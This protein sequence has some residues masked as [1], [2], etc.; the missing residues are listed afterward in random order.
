VI[1]VGA[2]P[3]GSSCATILAHD[4][5]RVL[6]VEKAK[7]P[8]EKICGDC[9]NP[10]SW[11]FFDLLGVADT[12][13]GRR[14]NVIDSIRVT[15]SSGTA[16]IGRLSFRQERPF[17][18]ISRSELDMLLFQ[19]ACQAGAEG[20]EGV[21][22]TD[23]RW[24]GHWH[25]ETQAVDGRPASNFT[26]RYLVG[27][28]G[29][30]SFVARKLAEMERVPVVSQRRKR[31]GTH[32]VGVQ[33]RTHYQPQI[34]K[35]VEMYLFKTGY[36]G[37]VNVDD[38]RATVAM[39]TT[40]QLARVAPIDL[41]CFVQSTL[42][43]NAAARTRFDILRPVGRV[44]TACPINPT[45]HHH[46]HHA[47]F[48]A[49]DAHQTV[50]PFTGEGVFFALQ[51]GVSTARRLLALIQCRSSAR[52]HDQ[53]SRFWINRVVSPILQRSNVSDR[54]VVVGRQ[55]PMLASLAAK[56]IMARIKFSQ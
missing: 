29:R 44:S 20:L 4:G 24:D 6:L 51:D 52:L 34:G 36:G 35:G 15:N 3:A 25:F 49:G 17:F 5:V 18:S 12:L 42:F 26:A 31:T 37:I 21:H 54:L 11:M 47:A 27:A 1:I 46:E 9:I 56:S 8:R 7:F 16:V 10:K 23:I 53:R 41:H 19:R 2:G 32:R 39:V 43:E 33:W 48:L 30:N 40:P 55:L 14:L 13:R 28:D 50:E 45:A 38:E 22:V